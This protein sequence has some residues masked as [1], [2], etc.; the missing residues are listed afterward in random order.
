MHGGSVVVPPEE[1]VYFHYFSSVQRKLQ[2]FLENAVNEKRA[3]LIKFIHEAD[4]LCYVD[5]VGF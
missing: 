1:I 2:S 4:K 3:E 5:T